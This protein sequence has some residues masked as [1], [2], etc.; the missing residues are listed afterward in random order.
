MN[1]YILW[2]WATAIADGRQDRPSERREK[3]TTVL[4]AVRVSRS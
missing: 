3:T 1:K 4:T 2:R